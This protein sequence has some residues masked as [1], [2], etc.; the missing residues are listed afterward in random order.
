MQE[1]FLT[2][3][4]E[5]E[6]L[7]SLFV[8]LENTG[9][10]LI[11]TDPKLDDNPIIHTNQI[12]A[13]RCGMRVDELVGQ[14]C[15]F[16]Q[17]DDRNQPSVAQIRTAIR[18]QTAIDTIVR[19]YDKA[20]NLFRSQLSIFPVLDNHE[21]LINFV[22]IQYD[23]SVNERAKNRVDECFAVLSHE[24]RT[25]VTTVKAALEILTSGICTAKSARVR[26]LLRAA[27]SSC[28]ALAS[29]IDEFLQWQT[30]SAGSIS[31][32]KRR[33]QAE[34]LLNA[35]TA[36]LTPLA[37]SKGVS[38]EALSSKSCAVIS[39]RQKIEQVLSTL[40]VLAINSC[41]WGG[42]VTLCALTIGTNSA[43]L[44]VTSDGSVFSKPL[45]SQLSSPSTPELDDLLLCERTI[46]LLGGKSE[47]RTESGSTFRFEIWSS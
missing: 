27:T 9:N 20:G 39:N 3:E 47:R 1:S 32:E 41:P 35:V 12:L 21:R 28:D 25:P 18:E 8:A 19:N 23:L 11:I 24:L 33:L 2:T 5:Y 30:L 43:E 36:Q 7:L 31:L 42:R 44:S 17:R 40:G 29:V 22:G 14:N 26:K 15:R 46:Y 38:L 4:N 13:D 37:D 16:L 10:G 34:D 6:R 45:A